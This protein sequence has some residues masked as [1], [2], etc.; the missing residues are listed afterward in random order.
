MEKL[1]KYTNDKDNSILRENRSKPTRRRRPR[2]RK[3]RKEGEREEEEG[4]KNKERNNRHKGDVEKKN[5]TKKWGGSP[6]YQ[7]P[8]H[9][10]SSKD[11]GSRF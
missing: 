1:Q 3:R 6:D 10:D 4:E 2:S 7:T 8:V 5:K 11:V 9:L